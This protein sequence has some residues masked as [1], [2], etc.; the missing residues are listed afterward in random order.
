MDVR[1][2]VAKLA[3]MG[4]R[5][6]C[7]AL[8]GVD[9]ASLTGKLTMHLL[10]EVAE[11]DRGLLIERTQAGLIRAQL[12]ARCSAGPQSLPPISASNLRGTETRHWR[13]IS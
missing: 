4:V 9:L 2:T 3:D 11:F 13:V 5:V 10:N 8:G 12:K 1:S 7:L 6:H